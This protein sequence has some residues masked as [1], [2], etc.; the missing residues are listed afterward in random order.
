MSEPI[1]IKGRCG[2]PMVGKLWKQ[3]GSIKCEEGGT[4]LVSYPRPTKIQIM[5]D[6]IEICDGC[7]SIKSKELRTNTK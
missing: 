7:E 3:G 1:D 2:K 4:S 5:Q 6:V